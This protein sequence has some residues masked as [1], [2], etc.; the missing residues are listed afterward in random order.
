MTEFVETARAK[1]N[2]TLRVHGRRP[3]GYHELESLVAFADIGDRVMVRRPQPASPPSIGRTGDKRLTVSGPFA[4][5]IIGVNLIDTVLDLVDVAL[6]SPLQVEVGLEK[7]LPVASGVGGGS[8]DCAAVLRVLRRILPELEEEF[9][10]M[11]LARR[12]GADVPVCMISQPVLMTGIGE[13]L[14][15][16]AMPALHAVLVNPCVPVPADKS[17]RVFAALGAPPLQAR[18]QPRPPVLPDVYAVV[19]LARLEGNDLD[20][21]AGAV[22]PVIAQVK[23]AVGGSRGCL[24][25]LLSGA[26]P[27]VVGLYASAEASRDAADDLA[28]THPGWWVRA[29]LIGP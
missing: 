13:H 10:W 15:A 7:Q 23:A 5:D 25:A 28:T 14:D 21:A 17:R 24:H 8:A 4:G 6:G 22:I 3:D 16:V 9:D 19:D 2:L 1:I 27:T 20:S 26:G 18:P 11:A 29:A 12:L